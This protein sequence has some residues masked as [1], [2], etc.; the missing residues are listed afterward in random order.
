MKSCIQTKRVIFSRTTRYMKAQWLA[1]AIVLAGSGIHG[2]VP[3][4]HADVTA[5]WNLDAN[6]NWSAGANW[7]DGSA[8]TGTTGV[9][10]FTNAITAG[11]TVTVDASPWIIGGV[12][13]SSTAANGFTLASG[14]LE[15]LES[16]VV[17]SSSAATVASPI[18]GSTGLALSG[19]GVLTLSSATN[20]FTG[21]ITVSGGSVLHLTHVDAFTNDLPAIT[22]NNG[23]IGWKKAGGFT[24]LL[25]K[26]TSGSTGSIILYQE[27]AAQNIDLTGFPNITVRFQGAFTYTGTITLDPAATE[28]VLS[29][30]N[31]MVITYSQTPA[32]SLPLIVNGVGNGM[33]DLTGDNS[34]WAGS[35]TVNGG[36]LS[37]SQVNGLGDGT[38]AITINSNAYLRI[39]AAV[40]ASF[41][42]RITS[43]SIGYIILRGTSAALNIDL[44]NLPGVHL[45][46]DEGTLN[47]TG[48]ITPAS[49]SV[50]RLGGGN[51]VFRGSGNQGFVANLTGGV[52][53]VI[54]QGMVRITNSTCTGNM[55]ITNNGVLHLTTDAA[56][57]VVPASP[58]ENSIQ[59]DTGGAI[60][61][62]NGSVTMNA[63]R[64]ITVGSGGGEIHAWSGYTLT[65]PGSLSGVGK[66]NFTD[67]GTT[68]FSG[69]N[70]AYSGILDIQAGST[71]IGN[72]TIFS[73]NTNAKVTGINGAASRFGINANSDLTWSTA[74]GAS[75]GSADVTRNN[76]SLLKRGTG[77]LTVDV[78][79][80][81][82]QDTD[83][84]AGTVKVANAAAI[85][86]GTGK[87]NVDFANNAILDVN[88]NNMTLNAVTGAG[89]IID[90]AGTATQITVGANNNTWTLLA[91]ITN[92]LSI[93]K[94]GTGIMTLPLSSISNPLRVD[95]GT[96]ALPGKT[97]VESSL[98]L[99]GTGATL[100]LSFTGLSAYYYYG[101]NNGNEHVDTYAELVTRLATITPSAVSSSLV[102][103]N[104]CDYGTDTTKI[105]GGDNY[106]L[107]HR[108]SFIAETSG[109]YIFGLSSDDGSTL[110]ING[111]LIVTNIADQGYSAT[112][113]KTGSVYL[114]A[115]SHEL[116]M[117][118]YEKA[119]GQGLTL[120]CQMPGQTSTNAL[121][122]RLLQPDAPTRITHLSGTGKIE[123]TAPFAVPVELVANAATTFSGSIVATQGISIVKSGTAKQTI[124]MTA[125]CPTS[126]VWDVRVGELEFTTQPDRGEVVVQSGATASF[127]VGGSGGLFGKYYT[128]CTA[129][130]NFTNLVTFKNYIAGYT[131]TY[132]FSTTYSG[133]TVLDFATSGSGF[134]PPYNSGNPIFQAYWEG[135]INIPVAGTYTFY[136][137]SDDGSM[138]FI[139]GQAIVDNSGGHGI[140]E[141]I[142]T[143]SLTEGVHGF[144]LNFYN[145]GGGYGL[146]ASISG[147]GLTKQF[148]PNSMLTGGSVSGI[149]G[150]GTYALNTVLAREVLN[151]RT[152][153]L[154]AGS[155]QG[156]SGT[157]LSKAGPATWTLTGDSSS[158]AGTLNVITG[159]VDFV[160]TASLGGTIINNGE[161]A[162]NVTEDRTFTLGAGGTGTLVK[163][164]EKTVTLKLNGTLFE[165]QLT[166]NAGRVLFDN[167]GNNVTM[168]KQPIVTGTGSWGF[169]G[170]GNTTLI[171]GTNALSTVS[172]EVSIDTGSLTLLGNPVTEGLVVALDA[173]KTDTILADA[174][175]AVT[176]WISRAGAIN[177]SHN[178]LANCPTYD[179]NAFNG[180]GAVVFGS[181]YLGSVTS[182]RLNS[183]KTTTN[184]TIFIVTRM[185]GAQSTEWPGIWGRSGQDLGGIRPTASTTQWRIPGDGNDFCNGAGGR[186]FVNG[187]EKF[188]N[189]E[190]GTTGHILTQYAGNNAIWSTNIM[191]TVGHYFYTSADRYYKGEIAELLVYDRYVTDAERAAIEKYLNAKWMDGA[192]GPVTADLLPTGVSLELVNNG[193]LDLVGREQTFGNIT[194]SGTITNGNAIV[195]DDIR[196]GGDGVMGTL[197]FA[198]LEQQTATYYADLDQNSEAPCDQVVISGTGSVSLDGLTININPLALPGSI[199]RF[200]VMSTL[201]TFTGA[202]ALTAATSYW[203]AVIS[204]SGKSLYL[205]YSSGTMIMF[206]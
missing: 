87:G 147:P 142:G 68:I 161:V 106:L 116:L 194:G 170:A 75:L 110:F 98:N 22:L 55:I 64:G 21:S 189:T 204:D 150:T 138:V 137:S 56:F 154:F 57:A 186:A 29:P 153:H 127:A 124:A 152:D 93:T 159:R 71:I 185:T 171:G 203:T 51:T 69:I 166:V 173:S 157:W 139:D 158:F 125:N 178:V 183:S 13:F 14:T 120:F 39:N 163:N 134:P 167:Q 143:I 99:N 102:A 169:V 145:S 90:S 32:S 176:N 191:T 10:Y 31:G 85:P 131:P 58:T 128:A 108:G 33:V 117:G 136:T 96:L 82:L 115:G 114:T 11:R 130:G 72:G 107:I 129:Y 44:T 3:S 48:T 100:G 38:G 180:R 37:V 112:P 62:G 23:S 63:N 118:M 192:G 179:P 89:S 83:I 54:M 202:P 103:G 168:T 92:S 74:L 6:G 174:N 91:P 27:N 45:G 122:N 65:V 30:E 155:L 126:T 28:L 160:G 60:R 36:R 43:G 111:A 5:A 123:V 61:L 101:I 184:K 84:E 18:S 135:Y 188:A 177:F 52:D 205:I 24:N 190:V 141:R 175:G 70:S 109:T 144:A 164:E 140:Q 198:G 197:R 113:Q 12:T 50:V 15:S 187:V 35:I 2:L 133:K 181:N 67:G 149:S 94:A 59:L 146:N 132:T 104:N 26:L 81:Y 165:Q 8:P 88:G 200:K 195:T 196:P 4:V 80:S 25:A 193:T 47:Y 78:A 162:L 105:Y 53:T 73:W 148:I 151:D 95:G 7:T 42:S 121:P 172:G 199:T 16:I 66:M 17:N 49:D 206:R 40:A 46:T 79:Q 182:T 34:S 9:A 201:G 97:I 19:G 1:L 76:F 156:A 86:S 77:T 41:T 20:T 119:G